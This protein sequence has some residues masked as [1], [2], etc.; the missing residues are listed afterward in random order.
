LGGISREF[1]Q[2]VGAAYGSTNPVIWFEPHAAEN[3]FGQMLAQAGV[4]VYTNQL[5]ASVTMANQRITQLTSQD[6]SVFRAKEFIDTTYEG[7][8]IAAAGVTFTWGR[9][10]TNAYNESLAGIR[11]P[12]GSY[13]YDP[14]V[15]AG[16][17]A[18]GLLP[19]VNATNGGTVGQGDQRLQC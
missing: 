7:D 19:L 17:P 15:V 16:N 14:Y 1:Y 13:N 11:S 2:R 6:G 5:L 18:S 8:L 4:A 3:V 10:G 12:G 9:E